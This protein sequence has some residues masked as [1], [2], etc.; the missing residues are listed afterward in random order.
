MIFL[1]HIIRVSS[2]M[3]SFIV[4]VGACE[5]LS[6]QNDKIIHT[7]EKICLNHQLTDFEFSFEQVTLLH[8]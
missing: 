4:F 8:K 6:R 2:T 1:G 3:V 5:Q 7:L